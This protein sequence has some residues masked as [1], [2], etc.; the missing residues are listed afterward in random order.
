M[1][2]ALE[3]VGGLREARPPL[4]ER[5]SRAPIER[6]EAMRLLK[7]PAS[8]RTRGAGASRTTHDEY[9]DGCWLNDISGLDYDAADLLS[10]GVT[11]CICGG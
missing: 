2:V 10:S 1:L 9:S 7:P 11:A 3:P 6:F 4:L 8:S 5:L